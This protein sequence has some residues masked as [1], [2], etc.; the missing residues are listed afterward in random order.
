MLEEELGGRIGDHFD[1]FNQETVAAGSIAQ[2][3]RARLRAGGAWVAIKVQR[4]DI[5]PI[6]EIDLEFIAWFARALHEALAEYRPYDL[7]GVMEETRV[8]LMR[9][10]DFTIEA[11][12]IVFRGRC[13]DC[14]PP[15]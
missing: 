1:Q 15:G 12:H 13:A 5:R 6:V 4:P 3:Y 10:M 2:I 9:E 7:P 11:T 14:T 8:G